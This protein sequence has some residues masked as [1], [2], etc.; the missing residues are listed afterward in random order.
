V[1]FD[2]TILQAL[3]V[4]FRPPVT[5]TFTTPIKNT[6]KAGSTVPHKVLLLNCNGVDVTAS[7]QSQV[8]VYLS[9]TLTPEVVGAIGDAV[10][11]LEYNGMGDP[12]GRMVFDGTQFHYNLS[13]KNYVVTTTGANATKWFRSDVRVEY[14][15][16]TG[17]E[18][19]GHAGSAIL[20][21]K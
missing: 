8:E 3:T 15:Y 12:G 18:A 14:L 16:T 5:Q 19:A 13:T 1:S 11:P 10:D 4:S 2:L 6:V 7:V 17:A 20:E 9:V 21:T